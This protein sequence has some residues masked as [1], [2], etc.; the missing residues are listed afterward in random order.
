[1]SL[2][3]ELAGI[4]AGYNGIAIVED[5]TLEVRE[6]DFI[7]ITGAN[8]GGKTTVL[9]VL[10][11]LLRPFSGII[12]RGGVGGEGLR[13]GYL[14][15][16]SVIDK[17][18]PISVR[19]V[20]VSGLLRGMWPFGGLGR[21]YGGRVEEVLEMVGMG[22]YGSRAIGKLSG[23]EL[24]RVLLGRAIV[25]SPDLLVLDEPESHLDKGFA[26]GLCG[27]LGSFLG[28][29]SAIVVASHSAGAFG[30]LLTGELRVQAGA[31]GVR[32]AKNGI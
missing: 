7:A 13:I 23:G 3:I 5:L 22:G 29:R 10:T 9:K 14:P 27:L 19:E 30:S 24:Q 16:V 6:G 17:T 12:R 2:L 20:I 18:F 1:M 31:G 15:Q 25:S 28:E 4:T 11:G 26:E 32:R 21:G 8:G